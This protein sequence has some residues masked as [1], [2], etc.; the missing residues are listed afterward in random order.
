MKLETFL[1]AKDIYEKIQGLKQ[2][3]FNI[4]NFLKNKA[5]FVIATD[6][7]KV[8]ID[9]NTLTSEFNKRKTQLEQELQTLQDELNVL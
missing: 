4:G 2:E 5:D 6:D 9:K 1:Q 8:T 7:L 3:Q